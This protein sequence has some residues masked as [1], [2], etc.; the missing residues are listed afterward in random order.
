[1]KNEAVSMIYFLLL[2]IDN[3]NIGTVRKGHFGTDKF[4]R[5]MGEGLFF[6]H[7]SPAENSMLF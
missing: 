1:M 6:L 3:I 7:M 4:P 2:E 5:L